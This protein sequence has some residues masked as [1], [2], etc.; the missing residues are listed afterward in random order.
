M[1]PD[2][3]PTDLSERKRTFSQPIRFDPM[4]A[5]FTATFTHHIL[6]AESSELKF[7]FSSDPKM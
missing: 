4:M 2:R 5:P 1:K 7:M 6:R 3:S